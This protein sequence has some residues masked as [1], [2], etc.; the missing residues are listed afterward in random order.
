MCNITSIFDK[1]EKFVS[2]SNKLNIS[3]RMY[4]MM[5]NII[6]FRR[7]NWIWKDIEEPISCRN[8]TVNSKS[9]NKACKKHNKSIKLHQA[10]NPWIPSRI[11]TTLKKNNQFKYKLDTV[12]EDTVCL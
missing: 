11:K 1:L 8:V 4:S 12:A 5:I 7:N 9:T 10:K 6:Q 3:S 2:N